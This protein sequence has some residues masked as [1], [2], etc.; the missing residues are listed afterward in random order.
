MSE[1]NNPIEYTLWTHI[2]T[3]LNTA[4]CLLTGQDARKI[5]AGIAKL[6][7]EAE[8]CLRLALIELSSNITLPGRPSAKD[9][10]GKN[11]Q[12]DDEQALRSRSFAVLPPQAD[13]SWSYTYDPAPLIDIRHPSDARD[14]LEHLQARIACMD[15]VLER[16]DMYARRLA[17]LL[18]TRENI[19]MQIR[20]FAAGYDITPETFRPGAQADPPPAIDSS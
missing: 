9:L 17:F 20:Y 8:A 7:H 3:L 11:P 14:R 13:V 15:D 1:Q 12:P 2:Y 16:P 6:I 4:W 18:R 10:P 19:C 5:Q